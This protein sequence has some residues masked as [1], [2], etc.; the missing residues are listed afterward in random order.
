MLRPSEVGAAELAAQKTWQ[1]LERVID[2]GLSFRVEAGAGSGKTFSLIQTLRHLIQRRSRQMR[3]H[4]QQIVCITYTNVAKNE[5]LARVDHHRDVVVETIH[6]F[7]W[8][9]IKPFQR[10]LVD[11]IPT[12]GVE[13]FTEAGSLQGRRVEYDLGFRAVSDECV[14]LHHDDVLPLTIAMLKSARFRQLWA[15][16]Y[17]VLLVDEYQDTDDGLAQA[18]TV[19]F[20]ESEPRIQLGLFGDH[21]QKIYDDGCGLIDHHA[22]VEVRKSVNYRSAVA[23][24][25]LLNRLRPE[26]P[27]VPDDDAPTG[28][29][30]A[31]HTNGWKGERRKGGVWSDDLPSTVAHEFLECVRGR[32]EDEGWDFG[33]AHTRILMLTHSVLAAEQGYAQIADIFKGRNERFARKEDD[34][35]KYLVED[36]EPVAEAFVARK[37]GEMF[38]AL[39]RHVSVRSVH[40]KRRWT[41]RMEE[42]VKL[43]QSATVGQVLDYIRQSELFPVSDGVERREE[44]RLQ[45]ESHEVSDTQVDQRVHQ[46]Q[47]LRGVPYKE[48]MALRAFI[49]GYS[50]FST[51]HGVKG[52]EY[53]NVLVVVGKGWNNYNFN[54]MLELMGSQA[55]VFRDEQ[56]KAA[57]ERARNLFYVALSRPKVRLCVLF[58][59]KLSS[60]ALDQVIELFGS[61]GVVALTEPCR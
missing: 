2:A 10:Q 54:K 24:V 30:V 35:I 21:W 36:V 50:P 14:Y 22:L 44:A 16:R 12:L 1:E 23:V 52:E 18:I 6:A 45:A 48:I 49:D 20:L 4:H 55:P 11:L 38:T 9:A 25:E 59:L 27:Q 17:P 3:R 47:R 46:A 5:I 40:D 26:L 39:G 56:S 7:C 34:Y 42:L 58:T 37:F 19:Y 28:T 41:A 32:L 15:A 43:R 57:F 33:A 53:E 13:K 31:Y 61:A 29:V 60:P 51:K 8:A